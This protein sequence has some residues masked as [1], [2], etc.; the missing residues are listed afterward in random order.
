MEKWQEILLPR[1]RD[2]N[3]NCGTGFANR[4]RQLLKSS[5]KTNVGFFM[6]FLHALFI[7]LLTAF[8][9]RILAVFNG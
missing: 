7:A 8:A 3:D 9:D 1:L 4:Q 2:Q 5:G 6:R